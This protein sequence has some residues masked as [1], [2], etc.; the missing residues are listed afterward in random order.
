MSQVLTAKI[1]SLLSAVGDA[2]T[3]EVGAAARITQAIVAAM[4]G[5]CAS[6]DVVQYACDA[7][8]MAGLT[9]TGTWRSNVVRLASA[10]RDVL[11]RIAS[12]G[13]DC[14]GLNNKMLEHYGVPKLS[15]RGRKIGSGKAAANVEAPAK[16]ETLA[17]LLLQAQVIRAAIPKL[18]AS[19]KLADECDA[20][21][22][23]IRLE[24]TAAKK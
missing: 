7:R 13:D 24:I 3:N 19:M 20:F 21:I 18:T 2:V 15:T 5:G 10:P 8:E 11:E 1:V 6:E 4:L 9:A 14:Y 12:E 16:L 22:A 17:D 23:T